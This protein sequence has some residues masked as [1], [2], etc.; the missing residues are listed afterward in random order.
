[1]ATR[2]IGTARSTTVEPR[3]N[4][5]ASI[6]RQDLRAVRARQREQFGGVNWGAACFGWLVALALGAILAGVLAATGV[7]VGL[8][9]QSAGEA[10]G[11]AKSTGLGAAVAVLVALAT[12]Y[13]CGGYVAGRMSRFDGARQGA[14][15]WTIGVLVIVALALA[16]AI[17]GA[18]YDVLG[19]L[20]LEALPIG[21]FEPA[22]GGALA[23]LAVLAVTLLTAI[24]GG[25]SGARY[26]HKIDR[27][28]LVKA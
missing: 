28:G 9:A 25:K 3:T 19:R 17:L 7:V 16:G 5:S 23:L 18:E 6:A 20:D 13:G 8:T 22:I 4:R 15:T 11:D 27:A 26:H 24:A 1:M 21:D 12:A 14:A 2:T 10:F